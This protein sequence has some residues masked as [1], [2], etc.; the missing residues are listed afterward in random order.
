MHPDLLAISVEQGFITRPQI[1]DVGF[2]DR[3]IADLLRAGV[4]DRIGAGLYAPRPT[5]RALTPVE[6]HAIRCRAVATRFGDAVVFSH[7]SAAVLHGLAVWGVDLDDVHVTRADN[8]RGRHQS[9]VAHH[10]GL[11]SD[12]DIEE[13]NGLLVVRPARAVWDLAVAEAIEPALVTADSALRLGVTGDEE[14]RKIAGRN[15]TWRGARHAKATLSLT[16]AKSESPGETRTRL[17]FRGCGIPAPETQLEVFDAAGRLV[18]RSD[19]GWRMFRHLA[20]FDGMLKYRSTVDDP[21]AAS[22]AVAAEKVREDAIRSLGWGVTRIIWTELTGRARERMIA[23][24][25]SDMDR[26]RRL[27]VTLPA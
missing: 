7:Q 16:D 5:Y 22:R 20:E 15:S 13:V 3:V 18:G 2:D 19:F 23:R 9:G 10:V 8:G 4:L 27:Y 24:L 25:R 12:D 26:S 1:L 17:V 21:D 6:R 11:L 14:L